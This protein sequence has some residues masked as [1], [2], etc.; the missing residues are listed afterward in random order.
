MTPYQSFAKIATFL[1]GLGVR[2][3]L[4]T[5]C[6]RD[7]SLVETAQEF[8]ERYLSSKQ[9]STSQPSGQEARPSHSTS[10]NAAS[11]ANGMA[12]DP[13]GVSISTAA[14]QN[15]GNAQRGAALPMLASACPGWVCYAEKTHGDY[16]LPHI[17]TAKSPQA[18]MGTLVKRY[19]CERMGWDPSAVYHC[20]VMPCYDKKLEASR[21]DLLIPG[22]QVPE[23]DSCLT[24]GELHQLMEQQNVQLA[25]LPDAS[26]DGLLTSIAD[27]GRM[28]DLG[29][30]S[31]GYM[32][33]VFR[34]AAQRLFGRELPPGRLPTRALRNAD[35]RELLL[36]DDQGN[37]LLRFA[38]AYG[39]RN[40]QTLM[41]K[42]KQ[43]KCEYDYI[44]IMACPGGCLNGGGQLKPA[45]GQTPQQLLEQL[46]VV[47]HNSAHVQPRHPL[48]NS[49][50]QHAYSEWLQGE[51]GGLSAKRLLHTGYHKREKTVG[52]AL[53]DW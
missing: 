4:D 20:S 36:Q 5:S 51:P 48:H 45:A 38:S 33:F 46:E 53:S 52:A 47:Y 40:I 32:E 14:G 17:S 50:L 6:S 35:F 10:L 26:S 27:G 1:K 3:V 16:V 49:F 31:G 25:A 2:H 21:D 24:T 19:L 37:V 13:M 8:V 42:I 11:N 44:E 29:G 28:F 12:L 22:T 34:T 15:G 7:F 9:C 23:V 30:G 18:V 39:F 43:R 41:R